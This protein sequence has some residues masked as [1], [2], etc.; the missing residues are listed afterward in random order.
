MPQGRI[1]DLYQIQDTVSWTHG[2]HTLRMGADIGRQIEVDIVAQNALGGLIFTAGGALSP[3]DNFLDNDLGAAGTASKTFGPTRID[4]HDW[5]SAVF[6]QDDIKLSA[7][8]T[9]NL[10][11]RYDYL[12]DPANSLKYPAVD[13]DNPF[14]PIDTVIPV[15]NDTN[16]IAPRLG[17]A[18]NPRQGIFHDG[19]TVFHGGVGAFYDT[20]FTNIALNSAQSSPNAPTGLLTS[21]TGRGL[22]NATSLL[23]TIAPDL[24]PMDSVLS[25]SNHL[26]NPLT[27]Q[28][29]F[30]M[31]RQL[32]AQLKLAINYVGNHG[33]KLFSNQQLNY[34]NG[35]SRLNPDRGDIDIRNT[36]ASSEYNSIQ[37]E[38]SRQFSHGLFFEAVYTFGKDLDNGSEVFSTFASPTSYPS[39]LAANGLSQNW[40]PSV[41]D[42]RHYASFVYSWS[43]IG[44]HSSNHATDTLLSIFTR[45]FTIAGTTQ[46]QSGSHSTFNIN[47]LDT[48]LDGDPVND[49]PIVGNKH[50]PID[51]VGFDGFYYNS[52]DFV[53]GVYYDGVTNNPTNAASEHWLVPYGAKYMPFEI[54]RN[55][56]SNPGSQYW[57]IGA[58]KDVPAPWLH[59]ER[60]SFVFKVQAQNFTN[61][62][63][64]GPLDVNLLDIG[65]PNYL[66]KR[67]AIEPMNRHLLLWAKFNF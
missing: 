9:V 7:D 5:R 27:W 3:L 47:G 56:F 46:F 15:K 59:L 61:H 62:D 26:V 41:W 8:L 32:P 53:P 23:G 45:H 21:T 40:G 57:N 66:N 51:T 39:N 36:N 2:R 54:G 22:G 25:V 50:Q 12:T 35:D 33:E 24:T 10:G 6:A 16:N 63:N 37:T 48:N 28:W 55:S 17:F 30:G 67:N 4:P 18:W 19:K 34:F 65:T 64:I 52:P 42:H 31:E 60:G 58:E 44:F 29:N 38:V 14:A 49:R 20:D 11:V 13:I 43:P 1:E